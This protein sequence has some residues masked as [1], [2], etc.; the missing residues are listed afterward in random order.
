VLPGIDI[1]STG[2]GNQEHD[3][4]AEVPVR[5]AIPAGTDTETL[6]QIFRY[7]DDKLKLINTQVK[8]TKQ[9]DF[10]RRISVLFLYAHELE[11]GSLY[12]VH[13]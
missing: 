7:N 9:E 4:A 6:K 2:N 5:K 13:R 3:V 11:G 10:V 12:L 1:E 8:A